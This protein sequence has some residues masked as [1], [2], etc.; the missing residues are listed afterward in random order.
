MLRA[1]DAPRCP[2]CA[3]VRIALA[4]KGVAAR[5]GRD[6]PR[7]S[8]CLALRAEPGRAGAGARGGRL[9]AAGVGGDQRV[10]SRSAT[11]SPPLLPD[12]PAA[13]GGGPAARSSATRTSHGPTTLFG[14]GGGSGGRVRRGARRRSTR[15]SPR[16][17]YLTGEASGSPTSR[18]SLGDPGPRPARGLARAVPA[19]EAWLGGLAERP[20]VAAEI[21]SSRPCERR[22]ARGARAAPR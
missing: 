21:A 15:R 16:C 9:G 3:R 17:P 4:E 10:S 14:G 19:T 1:V 8:P 12:D 18:T 2:Y 6:R 7:R 13:A 22:H 20:S 11:R 5:V